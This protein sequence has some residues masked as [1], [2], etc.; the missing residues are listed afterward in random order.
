MVK[1]TLRDSL[2][3]DNVC[4]LH[5]PCRQSVAYLMFI[6]MDATVFRD[7]VAAGGIGLL[8]LVIGHIA[9]MDSGWK[10]DE[11]CDWGVQAARER[12]KLEHRLGCRNVTHS[13]G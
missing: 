6:G 13:G 1:A 3:P 9:W 11:R 7:G 10:P 2:F 8:H 12:A 5:Y 4:N